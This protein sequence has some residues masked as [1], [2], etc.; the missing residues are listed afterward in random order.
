MVCLAV[1][2]GGDTAKKKKA[3]RHGYKKNDLWLDAAW[4]HDH[5]QR[6]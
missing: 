2:G 1:A 3:Y 4:F 5:H 6:P